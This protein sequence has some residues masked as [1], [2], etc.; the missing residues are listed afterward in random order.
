MGGRIAALIALIAFVEEFDLSSVSG[1]FL[2]H[3]TLFLSE[4]NRCIG[5]PFNDF[6]KVVNWV[7]ISFEVAAQGCTTCSPAIIN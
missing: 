4:L 6:Y 3:F 7:R 5:I 2:G 1:T